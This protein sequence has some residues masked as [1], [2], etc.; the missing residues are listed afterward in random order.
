[1]EEESVRERGK[2]ERRLAFVRETGREDASVC[3]YILCACVSVWMCF[4]WVF[5]CLL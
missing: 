1:M 4:V 3:G 2:G 5:L